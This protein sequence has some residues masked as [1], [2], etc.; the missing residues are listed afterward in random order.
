LQTPLEVGDR[1]EIDR[2]LVARLN[3]LI[4]EVTER[5][6]KYDP[7]TA[8]R[9]IKEFVVD[10]LSNWYVRR[11]RVRFWKSEHDSDKRAAYLTLWETLI[12][13]AKLCAPMAPFLSEVIYRNLALNVAPDSPQSVHLSCWPEARPELV[14]QDLLAE[15]DL[16]IRIIELGRSARSAASIKIRQPLSELLVRVNTEAEV[17]ALKKFESLL[18]EELNVKAVSFLDFNSDFVSYSIR[19]NLPVVGKRLGSRVPEFAAAVSNLDPRTVTRAIRHNT[20]VPVQL[21]GE[22]IDFEPAAFLVEVKSPEGFAAVEDGGYL[23]A[24]NTTLTQELIIEGRIRQVL[25]FVQNAR[26]KANLDI[27]DRIDLALSVPDDF[28]AA[29]RQQQEFIK[30]E[31]LVVDLEFGTLSSAIYEEEVSVDGMQVRIGLRRA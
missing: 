11:N 6:E 8:C 14:D 5:L 21:A 10:A 15:M 24:L 2:W 26:K 9:A 27:S 18:L 13:V 12:T 30:A 29:L 31:G 20:S 19:P 3:R 1:A 17:A 22:T 25:R 16:A 4:S 7:T 23:A 28:R